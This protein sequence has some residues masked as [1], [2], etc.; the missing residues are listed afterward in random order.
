MKLEDKRALL[1][2]FYPDVKSGERSSETKGSIS[3][4]AQIYKRVKT[5]GTGYSRPTVAKKE[6]RRCLQCDRIFE[7]RRTPDNR[8]AHIRYCR[9]C[10]DQFEGLNSDRRGGR[11]GPLRIS[12]F[13]TSG[14]TSIMS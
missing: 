9:P 6:K 1:L 11:G 10:K 14:E 7:F 12:K 3:T 13:S 5:T 4:N 2:K 8:N